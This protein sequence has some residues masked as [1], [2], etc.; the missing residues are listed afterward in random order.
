MPGVITWGF[1]VLAIRFFAAVF[2]SLDLDPESAGAFF[3]LTEG[4][5]CGVPVLSARATGTSEKAIDIA[6]KTAKLNLL[7]IVF[8]FSARKQPDS[9]PRFM[10][11]STR[12]TWTSSNESLF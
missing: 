3:L 12:F 2:F 1:G 7:V 4:S 6:A 8:S 11:N 9:F 10:P 5:R